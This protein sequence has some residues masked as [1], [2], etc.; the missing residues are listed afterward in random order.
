MQVP[1]AT[2]KHFFESL[3]LFLETKT[4]QQQLKKKKTKNQ[5]HPLLFALNTSFIKDSMISRDYTQCVK[6]LKG[7]QLKNGFFF[8]FQHVMVQV[9]NRT[10]VTA[11]V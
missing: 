5:E 9:T 6:A 10:E 3:L 2:P 7:M 11:A 1:A 4:T 8:F